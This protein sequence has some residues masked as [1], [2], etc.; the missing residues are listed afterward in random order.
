VY[1]SEVGGNSGS[2]VSISQNFGSNLNHLKIASSNSSV[3]YAA[4]G[5]SLYKTE[6]GGLLGDWTAL[7]G[8]SGNINS[9]AVH[10]ADPMKL[11]IAVNESE[12]VYTSND[13]GATWLSVLYNLPDFSALALVW[14]A[15][16]GEDI[17]YLGMNY[18]VYYLSENAVSW[19]SY[20]MSLPNVQVNELEINTADNKLYAATYG[21]GL[22]RVALFNPSSLGVPELPVF[23]LNITPNPTTG[24]FNLNLN[25]N[26]LV[27]LKI[28]DML[29][30]LV[31]YEKNRDLTQNP[32][33]KLA[34]PKGLYF[35]KVNIGNKVIAK[36][37]VIK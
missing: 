36:K 17:L 16:S 25:S 2:W 24:F 35:L 34:L 31:F 21:R 19:S 32:Q 6:D 23:N 9:I 26:E 29:G 37:L 20:D 11:A 1:K 7:S 30:K 14:D 10:P 27:L 3:M 8:F 12:K 13:G 4:H 22:W 33:I 15:S 28:Y 18:G 5:A